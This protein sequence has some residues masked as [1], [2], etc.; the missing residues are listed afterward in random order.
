VAA[1]SWTIGKVESV[2]VFSSIGVVVMGTIGVTTL[3]PQGTIALTE[4]FLEGGVQVWRSPMHHPHEYG[5]CII[6][7]GRKTLVAK[8]VGGELQ[9]PKAE[10]V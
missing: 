2:A 4:G 7:L 3:H 10:Q 1:R 6:S 5:A 8:A 9:A